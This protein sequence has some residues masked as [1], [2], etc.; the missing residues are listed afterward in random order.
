MK[1]KVLSLSA[2]VLTA[3]LFFFAGCSSNDPDDPNNSVPDPE[4]TILVKMRNRDNGGTLVNPDGCN[5]SFGVSVANNFYSSSSSRFKFASIG[6]VKGLGNVTK[7]PSAG[8]AYEI[9]VVPGNG[10]VAECTNY[11]GSII[12]VRIYVAGWIEASTGGVIGADVKYQ[13]PFVP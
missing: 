9:A 10:Y 8:W 13:S 3:G 6:A 1:K 12:Y 2:I 4:G 5:Y 11:D 7:I